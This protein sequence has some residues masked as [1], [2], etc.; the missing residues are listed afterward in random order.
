[1]AA[2]DARGKRWDEGPEP[3]KQVRVNVPVETENGP[4]T[5]P[6]TIDPD[7][8]VAMRAEAAGL[9]RKADGTWGAGFYP[10]DYQ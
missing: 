5:A 3:A 10:V 9:E 2:A 4:V 8:A 6:G 1:M 7:T